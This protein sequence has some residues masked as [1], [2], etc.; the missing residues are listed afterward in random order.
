MREGIEN[1]LETGEPKHEEIR[2]ARDGEVRWI[3]AP[4]HPVQNDDG[5]TRM[6]GVARDITEEVLG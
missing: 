3:E 5:P 4:G 6:V 2:V 1:A